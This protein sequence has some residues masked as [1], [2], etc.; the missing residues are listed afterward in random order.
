MSGVSNGAHTDL[1]WLLSTKWRTA[2]THKWSLITKRPDLKTMALFQVKLQNFSCWPRFLL[3]NTAL[4]TISIPRETTWPLSGALSP[5]WLV[6][7][8]QLSLGLWDAGKTRLLQT[9]WPSSSS[10]CPLHTAADAQQR[11]CGRSFVLH[12]PR[13]WKPKKCNKKWRWGREVRKNKDLEHK[14]GDCFSDSLGICSHGSKNNWSKN[15]SLVG[16]LVL[17]LFINS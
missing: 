7:E 17:V 8:P 16:D 14:L 13:G 6:T 1:T 2:H 5:L 15:N 3:T 12:G 11:P 4:H 10:L 9:P